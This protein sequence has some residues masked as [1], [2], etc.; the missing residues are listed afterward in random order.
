MAIGSRRTPMREEGRKMM[1]QIVRM[2]L[3]AFAVMLTL[4]VGTVAKADDV[5]LT[6]WSHEVDEPAKVALREKAARNLEQSH[7][8]VHVKITWYEKDG[9]YAALKTALPA[10]QGPDV[11]YLEPDQTEY[12]TNG[13]IVPLDDLVD[14]SK[15]HDW[16]RAVWT[17]DGKTWGLPP[18][19]YTNELS[20]NKALLEKLGAS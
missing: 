6:V 14:W 4:G 17:H 10:G 5:T 8:G 19:A 15:I 7:P 13:Y 2:Q 16:A 9:L 3:A 12:I 1:K 20:Y 11:F 18:A